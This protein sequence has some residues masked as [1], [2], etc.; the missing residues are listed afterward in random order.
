M[1]K[2]I[3][4]NSYSEVDDVSKSM[5]S[6]ISDALSVDTPG[7]QFVPSYKSGYWD[8]MTRFMTSKGKFPTGLLSYVHSALKKAGEPIEIVDNREILDY[9]LPE[10]I[11]LNHE[12]LGTITLRDYQY[13]SVVSALD[14]SRGVVNVATNGGKCVTKDSMLLT[15]QGYKTVERIFEEN[16]TP[17]ATAD[18]AVQ[19]RVK[20]VNGYGLIEQASHL[21]FNGVKP[22]RKIVSNSGISLKCTLN[23][24][25][26]VV[27]EDGEFIWKKAGDIEIGDLLVSRVG[28]E[29]Y[30]SNT[31]VSPEEA[32]CIGVIVADGYIGQDS[33]L[34]VTND[35]EIILQ[36]IEKYFY[37]MSP[38]RVYR[39]YDRRSNGIAIVMSDISAVTGWHDRL[40]I[41]Y[42]IAKD[43]E[44]PECIMES[45]KSVQVAFL[46]GYLECECSFDTSKTRMEVTS[47]S[48][49][50][51]DQVQLLL[52]NMGVLSR[53]SLK[54]SKGYDQDY[55]R[56][57]VDTKYLVKLISILDFR[58]E[59]RQNQCNQSLCSYNSKP[60]RSFVEKVPNSKY[61]ID[62]Y[63][64]NLPSGASKKMNTPK[65]ISRDRMRN[66]LELY[67][68]DN[69]ELR[70][71]IYSL[72]NENIFLDKVV[73]IEDAGEE[74]TFDVC[75]P[76]THSFINS[77]IINHNTEIACGIIQCLLETLPK[78]KTI[79]FFT[80]SKEIFMQ[81]HKRLE[82]R[83]GIKVGMIGNGKW[84]EERVNIIM[85]PTVSKYLIKPKELPKTKKLKELKK[86]I[87]S[88]S[89][90][91]RVSKSKSNKD[92][93]TKELDVLSEELKSYE[94]DQWGKITY[95]VDRTNRL[96]N[97]IVAFLAD[98]VHHAQSDTWYK[99]FLKLEN[100]YFRFGLTGTVDEQS[101]INMMRL[102]GST[103]KIVKKVSNDFLIEKGYSAKPTIYMIS[104]NSPRIYTKSYTKARSEGIINNYRR[105]FAFLSKVQARAK[106]GKQSLIIVD[107]TEHG[108]V[109]SNMMG[110]LF[111]NIKFDFIHGECTTSHRTK[112]L[113]MFKNGELRVLIATSILDEGVDVPNINCL[114]IMAGG[115]SPRKVLQRIGRGL[116]KKSD[117]SGLEVF[118]ALDYHQ[119][120]LAKHT[121]ERFNTY[122]KEGF[123]VVK[124]D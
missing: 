65:S 64:K 36:S 34:S 84:K 87:D 103:G 53:V 21:T 33:K 92:K 7:K 3:L 89:R 14:S 98:E 18:K 10:K 16:G 82:E 61:L 51:L 114:F 121:W 45:T 4:G 70:E 59:Q 109:I 93:Y 44:I 90:N 11:V 49:R 95:Q 97:S 106:S 104:V 88:C 5:L 6:V 37:S 115:K 39:E 24:P 19:T 40:N 55:F 100:A 26:L 91:I 9:N 32:Y 113:D 20:L 13:E 124:L 42:G 23:H 116:R 30:G 66:L 1:A 107:E 119:D 76:I 28:D 2:I 77:S 105:N 102:F 54:K 117:G 15:S 71:K 94:T 62:E 35:Q 57:S 79:A 83:L 69:K 41:G 38:K 108:E 43:K 75:M 8:G 27:S 29:V 74:P 25:L 96:L 110:T 50:L 22:V 86:A 120:Y 111:P 99:L 63:R 52:K 78:D 118:D 60:H 47:A 56:L 112:S 68:N 101:Q 80:H 17:C 31:T 46:S 48:R 85:I 73:T 72:I 81:S 123:T 122:K 12:S 67:P 58:T